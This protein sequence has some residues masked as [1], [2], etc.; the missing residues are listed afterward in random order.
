MGECKELRVRITDIQVCV[1]L[2]CSRLS[3][4]LSTIAT[5]IKMT[6]VL[7]CFKCKLKVLFFLCM[8]LSFQNVELTKE[9]WT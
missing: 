8:A 3:I 7:F 6:L 5:K 9:N 2:M 1:F 4:M